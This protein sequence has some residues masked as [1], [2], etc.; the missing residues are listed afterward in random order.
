MHELY[1]ERHPRAVRQPYLP[2]DTRKERLKKDARFEMAVGRLKLTLVPLTLEDGLRVQ[3]RPAGGPRT[4]EAP[5]L[6]V[7][8][9][10]ILRR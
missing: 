4:Q 10:L 8:Y 3:E 1:V 2:T 5:A 6:L 7:D 9:G